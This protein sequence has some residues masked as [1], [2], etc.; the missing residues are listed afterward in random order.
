MAIVRANFADLYTSRL[1][2]IDEIIIDKTGQEGSMVPLVFRVKTGKG[3]F[4][5]DTSVGGFMQVPTKDELSDVVF[6]DP[7]AGYDTK[8]TPLTYELGYK[9]SEESIEDDLDNW[10]SDVASL[11]GV[12]MNDSYEVDH[13]NVLNNGFGTTTLTGPDGQPL[14]DT[15]HVLLGSATKRNE[16]ATPADLSVSSLQTAQIDYRDIPDERG[17]KRMRRL[18]VLLVPFEESFKAAEL[19]E[20]EL[21][22]EDANNAIN[23][24]KGSRQSMVWA[25]WEYLTDVDAWFVLG[26]ERGGNQMKSFWWQRPV[27]RHD[28]DFKASAA[29][30][31]IRARW[32]RGYSDWRDIYGSPGA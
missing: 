16:L 7:L 32:I 24:I 4:V 15:A 31:K 8:Y 2:L 14:M 10:I 5:Q 27:T 6:D 19:L 13:A 26:K 30:T 18:G 22:P 3:A 20:S 21:N 12:S 11:L 29:M 23:T 25:S 17:L 9:A 28:I 1:A